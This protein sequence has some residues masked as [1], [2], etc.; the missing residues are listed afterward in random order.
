VCVPGYLVRNDRWRSL[1]GRS[2]CVRWGY[3]RCEGRALL[4]TDRHGRRALLHREWIGLQHCRGRCRKHLRRLRRPARSLLPWCDL[5]G[6]GNRLHRRDGRNLRTVR[7]RG[8]G[9]LRRNRRNLR[10]WTQLLLLRRRR[11]LPSLRG[12]RRPVLWQRRQPRVLVGRIGLPRHGHRWR[13]EGRLRS[14]RWQRSALLWQRQHRESNLQRRSQV[15]CS[16]RW[17]RRRERRQVLLSPR[18]NPGDFPTPA[19]D[20]CKASTRV[21]FTTESQDKRS[22]VSVSFVSFIRS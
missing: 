10:Q 4:C 5:H 12:P 15:R 14:L 9:L 18:G 19:S 11:H 2:L 13:L 20:L 3:L 6:F 22:V 17:K 7:R 8:P 1:H 16:R 21:F